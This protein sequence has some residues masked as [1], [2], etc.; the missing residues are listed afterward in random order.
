MSESPP[1]PSTPALPFDVAGYVEA[2]SAAIGLPIPEETRDGV[3]DNFERIWQVAR[4]VV[5]FPLPDDLETAPTFE[6]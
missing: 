3:I 4:P 2:V 5:E 1:P 6:P